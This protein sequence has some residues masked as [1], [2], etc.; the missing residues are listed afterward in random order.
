[1]QLCNLLIIKGVVLILVT[2]DR[3]DSNLINEENPLRTVDIH[4][5]AS[6]SEDKGVGLFLTIHHMSQRDL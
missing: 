4:E 1:M 5:T 2:D 6:N 3:Q